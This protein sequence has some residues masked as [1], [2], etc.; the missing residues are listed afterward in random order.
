[1]RLK[2][3]KEYIANCSGVHLMIL[4]VTLGVMTT[5]LHYACADLQRSAMIPRLLRGSVPL[6]KEDGETGIARDMLI[7]VRRL[8]N[9]PFPLYYE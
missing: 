1:M 9:I 2:R 8:S 4:Y 7:T 3:D 5:W 6:H